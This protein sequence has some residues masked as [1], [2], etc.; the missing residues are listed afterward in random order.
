MKHHLNGVLVLLVA[1]MCAPS[2]AAQ[3]EGRSEQR[4]QAGRV[5]VTIV[6]VDSLAQA[7]APF[8]V[9]RRADAAPADVILLRA[10]ADAEQLSDGIRALLV[11]RQ[12]SGDH[13]AATRTLRVRPNQA[14]AARRPPLPWA[15]RVLADLRKAERRPVQGV[16]IRPAVT[17]WLPRQHPRL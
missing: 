9:V 15:G 11:A 7:D 3:R 5:P 16:G 14:Q 17:I 4:S 8:I 2:V 1:L 13:P 6:L 10:G 12:A